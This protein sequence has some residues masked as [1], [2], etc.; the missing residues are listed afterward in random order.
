MTDY[1][2]FRVFA[3]QIV[4]RVRHNVP[5]CRMGYA[6]VQVDPDDIDELAEALGLPPIDWHPEPCKHPDSKWVED[7]GSMLEPASAGACAP[8]RDPGAEH[9]A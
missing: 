2:P 5:D 8:P 4:E 3:M 1:D 7:T 9:L 6:E